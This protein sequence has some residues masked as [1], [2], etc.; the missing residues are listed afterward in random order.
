[1]KK[2]F[3]LFIL[4]M[5]M[6]ASQVCSQTS[7]DV[8]TLLLSR[9]E[10][11]LDS[12]DT[13]AKMMVRANNLYTASTPTEW[14]SVTT[15]GKSVSIH[16]LSNTSLY[17]R[18]GMVTFTTADGSL[19]RTLLVTQGGDNSINNITDNDP[20]TALFGDE[21]WT[22]L[23]AG[24][25]Q[26]DIDALPN[27]Y[28]RNLAQK[29]FN[30]TYDKTYRVTQVPC[31]YSPQAL[32]DRWRAPGK[33]YDQLEGVT[34]IHVPAKS[35]IGVVV[36]GLPEGKDVQLKIVAWYIGLD[37]E[38]FD[39]GNPNIKTYD[40]HAG[41][42]RIVYD[43]EWDG[44]AYITYFDYDHPEN[45]APITVHIVEG[46]Q[47]GILTPDK[48]ND[49]MHELCKN[50]PN[51]CMDLL[52]KKVHSIWESDGLYKYCKTSTNAA[53]GYRQY[54]NLL[55]TIVQ[56]EHDLL[57]FT[58]YHLEPD[59]HTCAYVNY[60]YY[61]FQGGMGVSFHHGQ[62]QRVLNCQTMMK[63][64]DDAVWGFSHEWGHQHQMHPYFCWSSIAEVS[65]NFNSYWNIM[66]MGYA[67]TGFVRDWPT[68]KQ[69]LVD[70][71]GGMTRDAARTKIKSQ[72]S[73]YIYSPKIRNLINSMEVAIPSYAEDPMKSQCIFEFVNSE[74]NKDQPTTVSVP[75]CPMLKLFT[76]AYLYWDLKDICPDF[77]ESLRQ[78]DQE[79]GST[80]EKQDGWD[81]YELI[82]LAQNSNTSGAYAK[83]EAAFPNSCWIKD[84]YLNS[85]KVTQ[86]DNVV[87]FIL[88]YV[89]KWSRL[90]G[91]DLTPFFDA[92]SF[93][94]TIATDLQDYTHG[95]YIL[96]QEMYDEFIADQ[97]ALV[98]AGTLKKLSNEQLNQL[99]NQPAFNITGQITFTTPDI[100]N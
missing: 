56:W 11:L 45:Y 53:K 71:N 58:K 28:C 92:W 33:Y 59:N 14:L 21:A 27:F 90:T 13:I 30:G 17:N 64:D 68:Y 77:Y 35:T 67:N 1:M 91:Y 24:V 16:A 12:P 54:I 95:N 62:Q 15:S 96:T 2:I 70:H 34:G 85:G 80:I 37:G 36:G 41:F 50:A 86:T 65:N 79:G 3:F 26:Q 99:I 84:K 18:Q 69:Y 73:S 5:P 57:G 39:G 9:Q 55:D 25:T 82:A 78:M 43:Y 44:L 19:T 6:M 98:E 89:R 42:N 76:Y 61:M 87:P 23:K 7:A 74:D 40:L 97:A 72:S 83:L 29:L 48:S 75:L 22:T 93:F 49:E 81:K 20:S 38:K 63:K 60:T 46:V 31:K 10:L 51:I 100:P 88:N 66:R 4:W 32:S 94:R 8:Q 47:N 52:G